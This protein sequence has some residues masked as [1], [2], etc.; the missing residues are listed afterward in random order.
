MVVETL[1]LWVL[2]SG[3]ERREITMCCM[4]KKSVYVCMFSHGGENVL[5]GCL[6]L[7]ERAC[8]VDRG[9]RVCV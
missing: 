9:K 2:W 3:G 5:L 4:T 7:S 8:G 1:C 6:R